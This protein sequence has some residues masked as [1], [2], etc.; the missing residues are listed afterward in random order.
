[1]AW[2]RL[3]RFAIEEMVRFRS[4]GC[5]DDHGIALCEHRVELV[6]GIEAIDVGRLIA[7]ASISPQT[8]GSTT[9]RAGARRHRP[10]DMSQTNDTNRR[11]RE[12]PAVAA[13]EEVS[14]LGFVRHAKTFPD[15]KQPPDHPFGHRS[16]AHSSA[17]G[18][19]N[20]LLRD[21]RS[22]ELLDAGAGALNP[23]QAGRAIR[24]TVGRVESHQHMRLRENGLA[25]ARDVCRPGRR[26]AVRDMGCRGSPVGTSVD[27]KYN[28]FDAVECANAL[29]I[30]FFCEGR[31]AQADDQRASDR[32]ERHQSDLLPAASLNRKTRRVYRSRPLVRG[33]SDIPGRASP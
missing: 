5:C 12:R 32:I 6:D 4:S 14:V 27:R 17:V 9:Q 22:G 30:L 3:Q 18:Q 25:F 26:F 20:P 13:F 33:T 29:E 23:S 10:A 2:D 19:H 1:M 8:E 15:L 16:R 21:T 7:S 24:K 11:T 31:K 28:G